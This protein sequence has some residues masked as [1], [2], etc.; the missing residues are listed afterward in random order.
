MR[1]LPTG[2]VTFFFS[3]IE[4][5]TRL[6]QSLGPDYPAVLQRH[7]DIVREAIAAH[8][9]TEVNTEG[10]SFFAVFPRAG[11][12]VT[13]A[14]E[15]QRGLAAEPW[16]GE[17]TVRVRIGLH[18]GEGTRFAG[19]DYVGL[20]VHRAARIMSAAHGGQLLVSDATRA[21]VAAGL[22]DGLRLRDLGEHRLRDLSAEHLYQIVIDGL[23]SDF[24]EVRSLNSVPN[25]LPTMATE[26]VGRSAELHALGKLL[27][28]ASTRLVTLTGPGGIGK[29]RL[30]LQA[31]AESAGDF[32]DGVYF[33][34]LAPARDATAVADAMVRAMGLSVSGQDEVHVEI[35][36]QLSGRRT[37][38]LL[39]NFEQ[40]IEAAGDVAT[41]LAR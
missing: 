39:D 5:S 16:P 3:D 2:A 10:D 35:A 36:A 31:A 22:P 27:R 19:Q 9:G 1:D 26:L 18:S 24:G 15:V 4:G 12:G 6:L 30:A 32:P 29:T 40:V 13:A 7:R 11:E 34:D 14:A 33:V 37:L 8:A 21:L 38:L 28:T 41:L 25:N 17:S 23:P 20:D